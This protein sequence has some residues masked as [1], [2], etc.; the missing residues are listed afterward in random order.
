[1]QLF[2][3]GTAVEVFDEPVAG[4]G[5]LVDL[6]SQPEDVAGAEDEDDAEQD[7]RRLLAP[8]LKTTLGTVESGSKKK[9]HRDC[10][11]LIND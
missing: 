3:L 10:M 11:V 1:M 5:D 4:G 7:P 6:D 2:E 9:K 8:T